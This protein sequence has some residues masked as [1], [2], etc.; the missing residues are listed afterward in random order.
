M[1]YSAAIGYLYGL[2]RYGVKLGLE[3]IQR[4]L[5]A[6]GDP[7][8][9]FPSILIGGTNGKG[10]TA[11]FL[12]SILRAAGYRVGLYTSPHLLEFTERIQVDGQPI[13]DA[14]VAALVDELRPVIANLFL[15]PMKSPLSPPFVKGGEGGFSLPPHTSHPTFF[16]VTT[17][18]AFLHFVRSNVDYAVVE[19]GL[20]G[21]FDATNILNAQV[22]VVTNIALEH[23]EYLGKTL[24]AI[25]VEKAGI[26]K[27]A[28]RVVSAVRAP[29]ALAIIADVCRTRGATLLDIRSAYDWQI[30]RSDLSGQQFSVGEK[31]LPPD[32][33]DIPLLGRHQVANAIA[34]LAASRLLRTGGAAISE[35]AIHEGLRH[36]RW[37]GRLQLFPG[38]PLVILD[39]AHNPAGAAALRAFL[40]EQ[41]FAGR[42]T[43]V[44]GVL[45]DKNWI[46]MLQEL[47]PLAQRVILTRPE[48]ERAADPRHLQ[49]A[50]RV[51]SKLEIVE[52]VAE[53]IALARA[54]TDPEDAVVVTGSLFVISAALRALRAHETRT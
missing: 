17:A 39:G 52:D 31:G 40:V 2:Q 9:R 5:A 37:P 6:V 54:V 44:F 35:R 50:E 47:A 10:S 33:F 7:H 21:R 16:E 27:E 45:Q 18:L 36:T 51:C 25:A 53:A 1:T 12:S 29:E 42:V 3:N 30:H 15:A 34:A 24:E 13:A 11:A 49:E 41:R 22:A 8:R 26:I 48:S 4:L 38:R 23:E 46:A 32:T 19:V 20:G 43:L 14:D 28:T